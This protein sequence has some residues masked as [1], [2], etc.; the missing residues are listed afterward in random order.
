MEDIEEM[1]DVKFDYL[2]SIAHASYKSEITFKESSLKRG[3]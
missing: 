1:E 2:V 3:L